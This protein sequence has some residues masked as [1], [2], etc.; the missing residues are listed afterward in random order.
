[1]LSLINKDAVNSGTRPISLP[2]MFNYAAHISKPEHITFLTVKNSINAL[3]H[4][5][6]FTLLYLLSRL[7]CSNLSLLSLTET[8]VYSTVCLYPFYNINIMNLINFDNTRQF[9]EVI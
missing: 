3:I 5:N 7:N 9:M 2:F 4:L 6:H 1:M 8:Y